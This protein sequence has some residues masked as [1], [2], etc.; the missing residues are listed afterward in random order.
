MSEPPDPKVLVLLA[1]HNGEAFLGPQL[2][3]ILAQ[4]RVDLSVLAADDASTDGTV[5]LLEAR[6]AADPRLTIVR[7]ETNTGGAAPNFY[8]LL[9]RAPDEDDLFIAFA[10]QDDIWRPGK[11]ARHAAFLA[12][13]GIDGVSSNVVAFGPKG[14]FLLRKDFPQRRYDYLFEGPG[15]GCSQ[16]LSPR[17]VRLIRAQLRR[18]DSPAKNTDFHDWLVYAVCRG[19]GLRWLI[20]SEPTVDYRQHSGNVFGANVGFRSASSRLALMKRRWHREQAAMLAEVAVELAPQEQRAELQRLRTLIAD[21]SLRARL[22]LAAKWR[23]L[24]RRRRDQVALA[25]LIALGRW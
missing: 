7:R 18:A 2:D 22:A 10:D 21:T 14:R 24:R 6:A 25:G 20:D 17:L 11:L 15:P 9:L 4:E 23:W 13:G 5:A 3:S 19:A 12:D 8:D 1:T 16:L